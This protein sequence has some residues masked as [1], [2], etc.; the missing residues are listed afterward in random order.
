MTTLFGIYSVALMDI[1]VFAAALL[2]KVKL[3][4]ITRNRQKKS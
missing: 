2:G 3:M 4:A 1:Y